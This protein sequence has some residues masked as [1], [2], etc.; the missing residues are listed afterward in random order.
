[1]RILVVEDEVTLG[2][3]LVKLLKKEHYAVDLARDGDSASELKDV[4]QY[5]LIVLDWSIPPPT[6][7]ELLR[8]W[9]EAGDETPV[10][11]L[12]ARASTEDRVDGLDH[13]ADDY[14]T[15]PFAFEELLARIRSLLRR[16]PRALQVR[17]EIADVVMD[18]PGR[19][20]TVG[21]EQIHL[22]PK[23]FAL[24]E[25]LLVRQGEVVSRT[26]L[27]EHVWDDA[28]DAMSNTVDVLIHRVRKKID[29][30]RESPLLQTV[31]GVGYVLREGAE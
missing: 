23:E 26:E 4:N 25:Y 20:V 3:S 28:F 1:M 9:R 31:V 17:L 6:G 21:G 5:D 7:I 24:L 15:K 14:L 18:R 16:R 13:G 19:A 12:T 10:L 22:S 27:S 2:K 30:R 29:G 8:G 11:M